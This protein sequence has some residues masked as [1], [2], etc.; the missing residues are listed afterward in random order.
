M[1]I[2][3]QRTARIVTKQPGEWVNKHQNVSQP[4][5]FLHDVW[6]PPA[7]FGDFFDDMRLTVSLLQSLVAQSIRDRMRLRA[8]G[9]A[10][11]LSTCAVSE[12]A[13]INTK[14]L[15]W[16]LQLTPD[17][18]SSRYPLDP[19]LLFLAQCGASVQQMNSYLAQRGRALRTSGASNGQTIVGAIS[20]GTHG[21]AIDVGS[22]QDSVLG[23]H[24]IVAPDRHIWLERASAP[25]VSDAFVARLGAELVR[26]DMLFDAAL[27][28][29]GCFG[30]IHAVLI[31]SEPLYL[32]EAN[33]QKV[34]IDNGLHAAVNLHDFSGVRLPY[35]A[36]RPHHFEVVFNPHD[37]RGEATVTSMYKRPYRTDYQKP[38][39]SIGG[40]GPGDDLLGVVGLMNDAV[41]ALVPGIVNA[42]S[43]QFYGLYSGLWGTHGEIFSG[44]SIQGR[45]TS[46][47]F[48]VP[49][50]SASFAVDCVMEAHRTHGPFAG[51]VA[52]RYVPRSRALLAFTRFDKTCTIE[53]PGTLSARSEGLYRR[54]WEVLD[55]AGI[56]YTH[57]WG[58]VNNLDPA[59]M[60]MIYGP[61]LDRWIDA[62]RTLL[63]PD[64][65]RVFLN[66]FTE[67]CGIE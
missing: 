19:S 58:Q 23:L 11:S 50:E 67:Q 48:G 47:E 57:H 3:P 28:S 45:G 38:A 30:L 37:T 21:S 54:I 59:R 27:V 9:G 41:P 63:S 52:L 29:F 32:L 62:R 7:P 33:R 40:V 1:M 22:M 51:F 8:Y 10:W 15:D 31:E 4:L 56:P 36:E 46:I 34:P 44:S 66:R 25:T 43:G 53:L 35:P 14:P 17:L 13:M 16:I 60:R 2:S 26:D 18:V 6:N 24:L 39:S 64:V 65:R 5:R 61:D 55:F 49:M 12:G 42:L 20:T